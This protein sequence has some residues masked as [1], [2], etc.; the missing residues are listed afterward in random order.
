MDEKESQTDQVAAT[1]EIG[2]K[3]TQTEQPVEKVRA[4]EVLVKDC[5][6]ENVEL[7]C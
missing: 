3:E 4:Q 6:T 2:F 7:V 1:H 5:Q